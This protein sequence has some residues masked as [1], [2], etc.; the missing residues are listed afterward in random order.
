MT[1]S[2]RQDSSVSAQYDAWARV[3]DWFWARYMNGTLPVVRRMAD[4]KPNERMLDLACG[5]GELLRR[6]A[7]DVPGVALRGVDL[8][9]KMVERARHK[10][11]DVP[12]ARIER[13]DAHELPFAGDTFDVVACAN[14]FHYFTHPVAVL[15]EVRRVLRPGG[16]LVL[17]DWCRDYWTC[18]VMDRVLRHIDPAYETCYTLPALTTMLRHATFD[19][20]DAFR[21]RFDFV[22]GMMGAVARPTGT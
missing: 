8:A 9:P 20:P 19:V 5:T 12:N 2:S 11:A 10:L 7:K 21:Y 1:D 15:G 22:W 14:T 16:R 18:R 17:L 3:Y 13:A 4:A 6:I